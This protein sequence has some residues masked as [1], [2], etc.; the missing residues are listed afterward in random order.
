MGRNINQLN[1]RRGAT[2]TKPGRH[3]DGGN[4]Y[5]PITRSGGRSW[6][7]MFRWRGKTRE[8]GLGSAR[9][10]TLARARELAT[11]ARAKLAEG[12]APASPRSSTGG[13]TF[14]DVADRL[15]E[16]MRPGWRNARHASQWE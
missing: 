13:S 15:V 10:V 12:I 4:L 16:A 7:F 5:L 3:A 11:E 8:I 6:V 14:A 1:A 2:P 9:S